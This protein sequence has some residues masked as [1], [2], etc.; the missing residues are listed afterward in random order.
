[1][2]PS[3]LVRCVWC[4]AETGLRFARTDVTDSGVITRAPALRIAGSM[5]SG[6]IFI[7]PSLHNFFDILATAASWIRL[8][9]KTA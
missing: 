8:K 3:T 6:N 9:K 2:H 1:M 7:S 4:A 5:T